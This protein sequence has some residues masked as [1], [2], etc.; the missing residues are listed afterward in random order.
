MKGSEDRGAARH[1][2]AGQHRRQTGAGIRP[3]RLPVR[4]G[5]QQGEE[6]DLTQGTYIS[7][8][9]ST[10]REFRKNTFK[11]FYETWKSHESLSATIL[12]AH[13]KQQTFY[14]NARKYENNLEAALDR[15][16][17]PVSVYHNLIDTVNPRLHGKALQGEYSGLWRYRVG[18]YRIIANIQDETITILIVD[19]G[20]RS[21]I[22]SK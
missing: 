11:T 4:E 10:D 19:I 22:Y 13:Y 8:M 14:A 3:S 15:T 5:A 6:H 2:P 12:D 21:R 1:D 20:H 16:E 9:E 17:V 18:K 7:Y